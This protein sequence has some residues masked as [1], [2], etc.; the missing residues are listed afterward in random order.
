MG[1]ERVG[2]LVF[3]KLGG[4]LITDKTGVEAARLLV[5]RR[6]AKEIA[7]ARAACPDMRLLLGHGSGSF[8]HS[9]GQRHGT[10]AGVHSLAEWTGFAQTAMAAQRLNRVVA[11]ALWDA[12][13]PI[14]SL[15]PSASALCRDGELVAMSDRPVRVAL[16]HGLVPLVYGDVALDE[17]RGGTII[18][19]EELFVWLA[20]RLLPGRILLVGDMPGVMPVGGPGDDAILPIP[21]I[22]PETVTGLLPQL[23][24]SQG[25]DVTGGML[26]KVVTMCGLVREHPGLQVRLVS[27]AVRGLLSEVLCGPEIGAGTLIASG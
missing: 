26:G 27:G 19:T 8:G 13:V 11:S 9:A 23:G 12:A 20:R 18:S 2:E 25:V 4:S 6:L 5:I 7:E 1:P 3:V 15:Q 17:V 24:G 22:T 21:R 16:E 10:R 14:W